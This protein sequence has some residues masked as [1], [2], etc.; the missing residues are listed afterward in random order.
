MRKVEKIIN[1][2]LKERLKGDETE[3]VEFK[4][5]FNAEAI[6]SL[7]AFANR[8]GGT[9]VRHHATEPL[10]RYSRILD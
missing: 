1:P 3:Q 10:L 7:V 8:K 2:E 6:E 9:V 5:S 4:S